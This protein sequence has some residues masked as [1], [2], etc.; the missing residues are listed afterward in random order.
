[1]SDESVATDDDVPDELRVVIEEPDDFS[2]RPA[3]DVRGGVQH[4]GDFLIEF[5]MDTYA[6]PG[7]AIYSIEDGQPGE[8]L[9]HEDYN[10]GIVRR[11]QTGIVMSQ[12]NAFGMATWVLADLLGED[13]TEDD[14]ENALAEAFEDEL[15]TGET[16]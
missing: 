9:R 4:R 3:S 10:S 7:A 16:E 1:M 14:I 15:Q 5:L 8:F 2:V 13:V 6:D 11:K 12:S